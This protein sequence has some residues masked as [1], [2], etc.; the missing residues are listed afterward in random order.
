MVRRPRKFASV[1]VG[2]SVVGGSVVG[3]RVVSIDAASVVAGLLGASAS[4]AAPPHALRVSAARPAVTVLL[5]APA[6]IF[7]TNPS[8]VPE[9]I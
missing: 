1:V 8:A 4:C 3:A 5:N 7:M 6:L 2:G 9:K